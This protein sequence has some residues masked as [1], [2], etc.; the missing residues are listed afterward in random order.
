MAEG[1]DVSERLQ[2]AEISVRIRVRSE[3]EKESFH[4]I[5]HTNSPETY[6]VTGTKARE[7]EIGI[8]V[9]IQVGAPP[10]KGIH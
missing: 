8:Q 2:S 4:S 6:S 5:W 3:T 9:E 1:R 7:K 10:I